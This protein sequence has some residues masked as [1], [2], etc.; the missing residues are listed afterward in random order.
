MTYLLTGQ[1]SPVQRLILLIL[2]SERQC[3]R[4]FGHF[5]TE[6]KGVRSIE[7]L[8]RLVRICRAPKTRIE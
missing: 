5:V 1:E 3:R 7:I 4:R 8:R 2:L 6:I